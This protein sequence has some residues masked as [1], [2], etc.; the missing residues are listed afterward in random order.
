VGRKFGPGEP[1]Q[2]SAAF[3][4]AIAATAAQQNGNITWGQLMAHG[5]SRAGIHHRLRMGRLHRVYR[6][7]Y[8]VGR[9]PVTPVERAAAA[10]LACGDG[11]G[12]SHG[13]AMTLWGFWK[14]WD[15]PLEVIIPK[16]RRTPGIKIH[17]SRT[18]SRRDLTTQLGIRVTTPARTLLDIAPRLDDRALTRA[19]NNA[20]HSYLKLGAMAELLD[21]CPTHLGTPRVTAVVLRPGG[22]TRSGWEDDFPSF[23]KRFDLP[24]PLMGAK[25]G[26]DTV[27]ALFVRERVI[28]ELDGYRYHS[29]PATFRSDRARD[30]DHLADGYVTVRITWDRIHETAIHEAAQLHRILARRRAG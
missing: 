11:A 28:I 21:R 10:V 2:H 29:D 24:E 13:S 1:T 19:V 8:S 12:L 20:Q 27:D 26:R 14:R 23:C 18:L 9:P 25:I 15:L 30:R 16:D 6:S 17:R 22:P 4:V 5:L 7:V 3:D